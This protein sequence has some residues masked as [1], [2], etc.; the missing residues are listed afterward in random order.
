MPDP[1]PASQPDIDINEDLGYDGYSSKR[2]CPIEDCEASVTLADHGYALRPRQTK[3]LRKSFI[4]PSLVP[5]IRKRFCVCQQFNDGRLYWQC[6][7]CDQHFH[8]G[9]AGLL[10]WKEP[11]NFYCPSCKV[12]FS[13]RVK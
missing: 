2:P 5:N 9:C 8:P 13:F 10:P 11:D 1:S 12:N 7:G 3:K 4:Y 6:D